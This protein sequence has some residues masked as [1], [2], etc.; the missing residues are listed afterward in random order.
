MH[1]MHTSQSSRDDV[2]CVGDSKSKLGISCPSRRKFISTVYS[3]LS[4]APM[5]K[6]ISS[7]ICCDTCCIIGF[8]LATCHWQARWSCW[9]KTSA[10]VS[11]RLWFQIPPENTY[12]FFHRGSG[13]HQVYSA[14]EFTL[15]RVR[16]PQFI[17]TNCVLF[18]QECLLA[19]DLCLKCD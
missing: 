6:F 15:G 4:W 18:G 17:W 1:D 12:N 8:K 7:L 14:H 13:K 2:T 5:K 16:N 10:L 19:L 11:R 9:L 3:V